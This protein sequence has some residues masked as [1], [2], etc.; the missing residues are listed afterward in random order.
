MKSRVSGH[1]ACASGSA[2]WIHAGNLDI[3]GISGFIDPKSFHPKDSGQLAYA[4]TF[5]DMLIY[6]TS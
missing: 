6:R 5:S 3:G 4:T 2:E 1:N